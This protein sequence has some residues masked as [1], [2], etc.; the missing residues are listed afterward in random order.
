MAMIVIQ[1]LFGVIKEEGRDMYVFHYYGSSEVVPHR[2]CVNNIDKHVP[3]KEGCV[4]NS[5]THLGTHDH[6]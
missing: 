3:I 5:I 1:W 6:R 4:P 2:K